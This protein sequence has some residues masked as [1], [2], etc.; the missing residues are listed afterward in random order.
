MQ[1]LEKQLSTLALIDKNIHDNEIN[2]VMQLSCCVAIG[3]QPQVSD[4]RFV[5]NIIINSEYSYHVH[6]LIIVYYDEHS[7]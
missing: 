6:S 4:L 1:Q 7:L 5:Y 3:V 2:N